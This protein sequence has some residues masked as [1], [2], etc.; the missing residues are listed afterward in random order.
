M[1]K[2]K[3]IEICESD[4]SR[5]GVCIE[6]TK[7]RKE[8][9]IWSWYDSCCGTAPQNITL[10]ELIKQLDIPQKDMMK[11]YAEIENENI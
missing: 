8:F 2:P 1:A 11:V 9:C 4:W 7:S 5:S 6:Y 3:R 10:K